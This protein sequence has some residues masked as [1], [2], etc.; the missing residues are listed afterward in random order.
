MH[1]VEFVVS[2]FEIVNK[3]FD[4]VEIKMIRK[5]KV[6]T[7]EADIIIF[8]F[9]LLWIFVKFISAHPQQK[10]I[11]RDL[12]YSNFK[13]NDLIFCDGTVWRIDMFN[14]TKKVVAFETTAQRWKE[15]ALSA[16][17]DAGLTPARTDVSC[18]DLHLLFQTKLQPSE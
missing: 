18:E 2:C 1:E 15:W 14:R 9:F 17:P 13:H 8:A 11:G 16:H 5:I 3:K 4:M 7:M 12:D 10:N 6:T